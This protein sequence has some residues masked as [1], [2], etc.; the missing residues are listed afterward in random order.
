M[1]KITQPHDRFLKALLSD[2]DKAGTLLREQ[3][4]KEVTELLSSEP[5]ELVDGSFIDGEFREHLTDRLFRVKSREGKAA[6]IYTLVEHKS[7]NDEWVAFQLL[8]YM[9]RIWERLIQ[10]KMQKLPPIVPLVVYHGAREWKVPNHFSA[11]IEADES[12]LPHLL[13]FSF[14]VTDLGRVEDDALSEDTRLR[15]ALMAMKYAFQGAEGVVVFPQIGKGTQG[16]PDFAKLVLRYLIQTYRGM[17]MADVQAYAEEAFPGEAEEYASLFA[18]EMMS[19][20]RQEG[21]QEGEAALLLRQLHRCFG[22]LPAWVEEKI[23]N[24]G[25]EQIEVWTDR[26]FD[27]ESLESVFK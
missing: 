12:L 1:T 10:K 7:Y 4:P 22:E 14:A 5:P 23:Q 16:D 20:G 11:L 13:D 19:K 25:V 26:V 21:R 8:R 24:S 15:A 27:G 6:Y 9:V 2:P 3:L 17:T 18:R